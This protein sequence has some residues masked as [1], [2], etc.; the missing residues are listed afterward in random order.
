M[1]LLDSDQTMV[2]TLKVTR[3]ENLSQLFSSYKPKNIL[4]PINSCTLHLSSVY[5]TKPDAF[6]WS[7]GIFG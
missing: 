5:T 6:Y 2:W 1:S 3:D 4:S 7:N